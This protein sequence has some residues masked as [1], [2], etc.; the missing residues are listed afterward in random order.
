MGMENSSEARRG[1]DVGTFPDEL[2]AEK[3]PLAG[4]R[5]LWFRS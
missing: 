4:E 2:T 1:S 5:S 3:Y